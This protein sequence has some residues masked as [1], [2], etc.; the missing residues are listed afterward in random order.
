MSVQLQIICADDQQVRIELNITEPEVELTTTQPAL[1]EPAIMQPYEEPALFSPVKRNAVSISLAGEEGGSVTADDVHGMFSFAGA[2]ESF[3]V[4]EKGQTA[5][6]TYSN[7]QAANTAMLLNDSFLAG[8][9]VCVSALIAESAAVE[10]C[11]PVPRFARLGEQEEEE[12]ELLLF[13]PTKPG[14]LPQAASEHELTYAR[15]ALHSMA[16]AGYTLGGRALSFIAKVDAKYG[17]SLRQSASEL[18]QAASEMVA[19]VSE[20][21]VEIT[22]HY[23]SSLASNTTAQQLSSATYA[24]YATS[25]D[26]ASSVVTQT[27]EVASI[28]AE[29][30]SQARAPPATIAPPQRRHSA[31]TATCWPARSPCACTLP[32]NHIDNHPDNHPSATQPTPPPPNPPLR[33]CLSYRPLLCA[34]GGDAGARARCRA[35]HLAG[36]LDRPARRRRDGHGHRARHGAECSGECPRVRRRRADRRRRRHAEPDPAQAGPGPGRREGARPRQHRP[37][38]GAAHLLLVPLPRQGALQGAHAL[39]TIRA[40]GRVPPGGHPRAHLRLRP[41]RG[42]GQPQMGLGQHGSVD[43]QRSRTARWNSVCFQRT[44]CCISCGRTDVTMCDLRCVCDA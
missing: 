41:V 27:T 9:P 43:S 14:Q 4:H 13:S 16:A 37:R 22:S 42:G 19:P 32:L 15:A 40:L 39:P 35:R 10:V 12:D 30:V 3:E 29:G 7:E 18:G 20:K 25:V 44:S 23:T 11:S 38:Q 28:V 31:A 6:V 8:S 2:I 24:T 21:I 33:A 17:P 5:V 26:V 36:H 34:A 1:E